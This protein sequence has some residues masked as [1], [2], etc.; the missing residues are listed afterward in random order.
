M[1]SPSFFKSTV[2]I[3]SPAYAAGD[4]GG[5]ALTWTTI[6]TSLTAC[7]QPRPPQRGGGGEGVY[8]DREATRSTHVMYLRHDDESPEQADRQRDC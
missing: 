2:N 4:Y 7:I 1:I 8:I 3:Q 6:Y 5:R